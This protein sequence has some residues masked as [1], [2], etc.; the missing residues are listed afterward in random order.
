MIARPIKPIARPHGLD[1]AGPRLLAD[2]TRFFV[3]SADRDST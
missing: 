1:G 3:A 2:S